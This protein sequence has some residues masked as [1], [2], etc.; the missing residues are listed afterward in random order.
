[1]GRDAGFVAAHAA[2]ASN[3]GARLPP[4]CA[5]P[6][7][8]GLVAAWPRRRVPSWPSLGVLGVCRAVLPRRFHGLIRLGRSL[9][10]SVDLV[11]VP[12][13][14]IESMQDIYDC[15]DATLERKR[16]MVIVVAE[17]AMQEYVSTGKKDATGH[18]VYG[19][20]AVREDSESRRRDYTGRCVPWAR[21]TALER[22]SCPMRPIT[23]HQFCTPPNHSPTA[24]ATAARSCATRSTRTSSPRAAALSTLTRR[25][26]S[27][28]SRSPR[29][30]ISTARASPTTPS[31][32][33][34]RASPRVRAPRDEAAAAVHR[35]Q[36]AAPR[37]CRL[38]RAP[39]RSRVAP[40]TL[41]AA[42]PTSRLPPRTARRRA[43]TAVLPPR[44]PSRRRA[45]RGYTGVC[46]G[47]IHNVI[48]ILKSKMI[49]SGSFRRGRD[50]T[51]RPSRAP[52]PPPLPRGTGLSHTHA[53]PIFTRRTTPNPP[54]MTP[55]PLG[56]CT[57]VG[58]LL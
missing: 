55:A 2:L 37:F 29:T 40:C 26:S 33:A 54:R 50:A 43:P 22:M 7:G 20:P 24:Q 8:R 28:P 31:T 23:S 34:H 52:S 12:E 35:F 32:R 15:V 57:V 18:T 5:P 21:R 30:T 41:P 11:L 6:T 44:P 19:A 42:A 4:P 10:A 27:A 3:L 56:G 47:A 51:L 14:K 1:M 25:T 9:S 49:A 13:V 58:P 16:F 17:G 36:A 53:P 46:V 39:Y 48:V 38:H 45:M